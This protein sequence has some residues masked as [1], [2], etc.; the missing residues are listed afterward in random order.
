MARPWSIGD[1]VRALE[2]LRHL[3]GPIGIRLS[4]VETLAD[5]SMDAASPPRPT[6]ARPTTTCLKLTLYVPVQEPLSESPEENA[7]RAREQL[8]KTLETL[9]P[10][11]PKT[12]SLS[13]KDVVDMFADPP[14][15]LRF[16]DILSEMPTWPPDKPIWEVR[17][18]DRHYQI[19]L[20][21]RTSGF[22]FKN[23]VYIHNGFAG[24]IDSWKSAYFL[25]A[26]SSIC[27]LFDGP[28]PEEPEG[29]FAARIRAHLIERFELPKK[30]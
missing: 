18:G 29:A 21:G 20:D 27:A 12:V 22:E 25:K 13:R 14:R 30:S 16:S 6:T 1:G 10:L 19:F 23:R 7:V 4:S 8:I 26:Q 2:L 11:G 28:F 17:D 15:E 9:R 5:G 3:L 24:F